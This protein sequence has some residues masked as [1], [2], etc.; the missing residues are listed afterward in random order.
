MFNLYNIQD[1]LHK[2]EQNYEM[3]KNKITH[4]QCYMGTYIYFSNY[5]IS[6]L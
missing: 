2:L 5:Y 1:K 6:L 3:I 4:F